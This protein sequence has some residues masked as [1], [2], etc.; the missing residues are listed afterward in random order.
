M[1]TQELPPSAIEQYEELVT[2]NETTKNQYDKVKKERDDAV[3]RLEEFNKISHKVIE[4]V[5]FIQSNLEIEK[6]CRE[7]AEA[8]ASK[9]SKENK[10]LK[11]ISML[12]IA[13]LGPDVITKE[14]SLEEGDSA[15]DDGGTAVCTSLECQ[16]IIKELREQ[17][18][19]IQQGKQLVESELESLRSKLVD[20]IEEVNITKKEN[21]MLRKEVSDQRKLLQK[22]NRVSMLAVEEYEEL[23][24]NLEMEKDLREKAESL[25]HEMYIEQNK[26]KRQSH[27]LLQSCAPND[28]LLKA[29]DENAKLTQALEEDRIQHQRKVKEL[30]EKLEEDKLQKEIESL[31]KQM[32]LLEEDRRD[33]EAKFQSSESTVRDLKH[34]VEALQKRVQQAENPP[35]PPPPPPPPLPPPPPSAIQSFISLIRKKPGVSPNALKKESPAPSDSGSKDDIKR[36]AVEEMMDR[37]KK[38]VHLRPV[39]ANRVK[40]KQ[41]TQEAAA[42]PAGCVEE[43]KPVET[44][45]SSSA[46]QELRGIVNSM[47]ASSGARRVREM[48]TAATESELETILRRRKVTTDQDTSSR[49]GALAT[50]ESK[51]MPVLGSATSSALSQKPKEAELKAGCTNSVGKENLLFKENTVDLKAASQ[52]A[53]TLRYTGREMKGDVVEGAIDIGLQPSVSKTGLTPGTDTANKKAKEADSSNC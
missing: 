31:K 24:T 46:V 14:I 17:S 28:Q 25:A 52:S 30:E 51:S 23:Q 42:L 4:E 11:R 5:S 22:Y 50:L 41:G 32:D 1:F 3:K 39:Q 6:T 15:S 48:G 45:P 40:P 8:L 13:K 38:G 53:E 33:L 37:I 49:A 19:A 18:L 29:L 7:S 27:L 12:C 26:L 10:N 44:N 36:Q 47:N 43:V 9:L 35:P 21:V 2:E 16:Q 20:L 34:S